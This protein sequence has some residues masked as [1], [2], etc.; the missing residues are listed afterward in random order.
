MRHRALIDSLSSVVRRPLPTLE[1]P[2]PVPTGFSGFVTVA[3]VS[4]LGL[5]HET[6]ARIGE[7]LLY[8]SRS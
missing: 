4:D 7:S 3:A 1:T 2:G 8:R 5:H 6:T